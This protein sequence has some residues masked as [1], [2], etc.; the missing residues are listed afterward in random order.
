M[1]PKQGNSKPKAIK[2]VTSQGN[3]KRSRDNS[4]DGVRNR[5]GRS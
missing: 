5:K 3:S 4:K 2:K 1:A